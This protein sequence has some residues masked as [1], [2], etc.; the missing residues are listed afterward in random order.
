MFT[1][2]VAPLASNEALTIQDHIAE[3]KVPLISPSALAEG[4]TQRKA[5]PW[6]V[7]ATSTSS[8]M[9]HALGRLRREDSG[10]QARRH[11]RHRFRLRS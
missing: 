6:I 8:Q 5:N 9:S 1:I 10:F 7:R 2:I 3:T 4:V 11:D